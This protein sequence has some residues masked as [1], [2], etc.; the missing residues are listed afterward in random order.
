M[1]Y[2]FTPPWN[3]LGIPLLIVGAMV[4]VNAD[5]TFRHAGTTLKPFQ[6]ATV[7]VTKGLYRISGNPMYLGFVLVLLGLVVLLGSLSPLLVVVL[8]GVLM[9]YEFISV[10][11][12]KLAEKFGGEWLD[13]KGKVPQWI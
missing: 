2:V 4:N 12:K 3:L 11:E 8:F 1:K 7:L 9:E 5:N 13:Y 10:E 6:E